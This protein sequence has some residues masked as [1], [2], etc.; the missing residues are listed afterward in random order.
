MKIMQL[1]PIVA[2]RIAAGEVVERPASVL[3]ELLDNALDAGADR[4]SVNI[5]DGG[6][7]EI[8]VSDNGSGIEEEDLP[9]A[10][11]HHATSKIR[12]IDDIFSLSTLG[13]RGEAL[14]S[15]ASCSRTTITSNGSS[16]TVDNGVE[17]R[18]TRATHDAGSS[19]KGTTVRVE[20]LFERLPARR[21]FLKRS[22]SEYKECRKTLIEKALGFEN[23]EFI[24][25]KDGTLDIAFS[26]NTRRGR[27]LD[28]MSQERDFRSADTMEMDFHDGD[29][30][31]YALSSTPAQYR[32]DRGGIRTFINGRIIDN[33]A[34]VKVISSAYSAALPGGAFPYF[35]LYLEEPPELVDFNIHP[36]KRQVRLRNQSHVFQA[37]TRMIRSALTAR[38]AGITSGGRAPGQYG[39]EGFSTAT[40]APLSFGET[41]AET[42]FQGMIIPQDETPVRKAEYTHTEPGF[43]GAHAASKSPAFHEKNFGEDWL[44]RA[45]AAFARKTDGSEPTELK[46]SDEESKSRSTLTDSDMENPPEDTYGPGQQP[47]G[48]GQYVQQTDRTGSAA[49][50]DIIPTSEQYTQNNIQKPQLDA[51]ETQTDKYTY[52]GQAFNTFLIV[53]KG[54]EILFIDQHAAHERVLYE[55]IIADPAAQRLAVPYRFETNAS[56]DAFLSE[57]GYIYQDLGVTLAR[58]DEKLWEIHSVP[59]WYP[60][61]EA[62]IADFISKNTGDLEEA[63]KGL[64]AVIACHAAI[65]AG[66]ELDRLTATELL[67]KVF[68]L[69]SLVCPHGRSFVH[70]ISKEDLYKAVGRIV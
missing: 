15:I 29:I 37:V 51:E 46:D 38:N 35:Y 28:A 60:G 7:R 5:S 20:E 56:V 49:A 9:L 23:V 17:E 65:K 45:K 14:S 40:P 44:E 50:S 68:R 36:A 39:K 67:M 66:E 48:S 3:R 8:C 69:P 10:F 47:H 12:T 43:W 4:I 52:I 21:E 34:F 19:E 70:R 16:L 1:D 30:S 59:A 62:R 61:S 64:F 32:R 55:E 24:L 31:I 33:Y 53:Q 26:K 2:A 42:H 11:R 27:I 63:R 57:N 41:Q 18:V 6:M 13:F 25:K 58:D 22:T 54:E